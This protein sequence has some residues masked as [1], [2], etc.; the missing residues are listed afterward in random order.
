MRRR[1]EI[2]TGAFQNERQLNYMPDGVWLKSLICSRKKRFFDH[3]AAFRFFFIHLHPPANIMIFK[4]YGPNLMNH[5]TIPRYE[6]SHRVQTFLISG[7]REDGPATKSLPY[8]IHL[9]SHVNGATGLAGERQI[10]DKTP[11]DRRT[12]DR[13]NSSC[14]AQRNTH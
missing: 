5:P 9:P 13:G 6:S 3:F 10:N 12:A 14:A 7:A 4:T 2:E 1:L 8:L 11:S